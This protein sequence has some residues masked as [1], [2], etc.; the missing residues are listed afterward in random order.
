[1]QEIR[2]VDGPP[3]AAGRIEGVAIARGLVLAERTQGQPRHAARQRAIQP[4]GV[5]N[6]IAAPR[7]ANVP[8]RSCSPART[9][10][11]APHTRHGQ[12]SLIGIPAIHCREATPGLA[13]RPR[14]AALVI[15][16]DELV[17]L[18]RSQVQRVRGVEERGRLRIPRRP[19]K[20][21]RERRRRTRL[22]LAAQLGH[23]LRGQVVDEEAQPGLEAGVRRI[24]RAQ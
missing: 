18:S 19:A 20:G 11:A 1:M 22:D 4:H 15:E 23:A 21:V 17:A 5:A 7:S 6:H 3:A 16:V 10:G 12:R 13:V 14:D 8:R 2:I 24:V 9:N